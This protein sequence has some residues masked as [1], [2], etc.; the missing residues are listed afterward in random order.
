MSQNSMKKA[1]RKAKQTEI[2]ASG[3]C[4]ALSYIL[5]ALFVHLMSVCIYFISVLTKSFWPSD[6][7]IRIN[8]LN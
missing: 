8:H 1:S 5:V 6:K 2:W 7:K 4:T 3:R